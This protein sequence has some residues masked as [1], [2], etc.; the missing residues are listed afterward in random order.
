MVIG[1]R[2]GGLEHENVP[3]AHIFQYFDEDAGVKD[4]EGPVK[5]GSR[6]YMMSLNAHGGFEGNWRLLEEAI[7]KAN[8]FALKKD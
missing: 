3:A 8:I 5:T 7:R 6:R 4:A 1:G 2:T